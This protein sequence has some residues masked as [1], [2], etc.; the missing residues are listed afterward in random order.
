[1]TTHD[2]I[3]T[4]SGLRAALDRLVRD[5]SVCAGIAVGMLFATIICLTH[6]LNTAGAL[7]WSMLLYIAA[8]TIIAGAGCCG[9][10]FLAHH[11]SM[12]GD[13]IAYLERRAE[14]RF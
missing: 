11:Q 12:L 3:S 7:G 2:D 13:E 6:A 5:A 9:F 8:T 10:A 14:E 4:K 1:M